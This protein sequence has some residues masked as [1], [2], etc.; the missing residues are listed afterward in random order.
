M[1]KII[2]STALLLLLFSCRK[3]VQNNFSEQAQSTTIPSTPKA[4]NQSAQVALDW[5][6]LQLRISL[7][8]NSSLGG[9][10]YG[11]LGI[12]LYESVRHGIKNSVSLSEKLY[13]MPEMPATEN[14]NGYDWEIS[15]NAAMASLLRL[16]NTGLTNANNASID[17]LE[18]V[19]NAK[20]NLFYY[21]CMASKFFKNCFESTVKV[22]Y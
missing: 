19:Y 7:E 3:E 17:S 9:A 1:K 21:L 10:S 6:K 15:A 18:N 16:F 14:N 22:N 20:L 12:G 4:E 8:R 11:Y 2:I 13:Q 5:Y